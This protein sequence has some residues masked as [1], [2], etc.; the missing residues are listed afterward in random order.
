M[1]EFSKAIKLDQ[2]VSL[3]ERTFALINTGMISSNGEHCMGVVMNKKTTS[4]GYF[5]SFGRTFDWL[6][7][8]LNKHFN[9]VHKTETHCTIRKCLDVWVTHVIFHNQNDGPNE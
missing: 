1:E 4:C 9:F 8:T 6:E 5:D 3:H 7:N 2:S